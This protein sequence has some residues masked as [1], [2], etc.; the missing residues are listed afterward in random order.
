MQKTTDTTKNEDNIQLRPFVHLHT[1]TEFSLLDGATRI[2][3]MFKYAYSIGQPA[4]AITDH[5][6]MYG[7]LEFAKAAAK[8]TD[9]QM[10]FFEFMAKKVPFK[11]KP[12]I[13]C[14]VYMCP[15]RKAKQSEG[16][17]A[18]KLEHLVLLCK[19]ETGY[20]NLI[21]M[22]SIAN[23]EGFY[24][25]PRIDIDLL[26]QHVE[27]LVCLSGCLG[28]AV[29][30]ALLNG[31]YEKANN[32]A[33][34]FKVLFG[35]DY[36]IEIQ[37][38]N[39]LEQ[40][41]VLPNLIRIARENNIKL[42]ATND[43]HY[44]KKEDWAMQKVLQCIA[45]RKTLSPD[46]LVES[47]ATAQTAPLSHDATASVS[48]DSYF[49]THEYYIKNREEMEA[50]FS[51]CLD[52]IDNTIEI[53]NKCEPYFFE[54]KPLLPKFKPPKEFTPAK[55]LRKLTYDGLNKKYSEI[56][57]EIKLRADYE[58]GLIEKLGFVD[59]FLIVWDFI[60]FAENKGIAVGPGRGSGVGS[61]VAFALN[62]TKPDPL[63]YSL[64]FERFLNPDRISNPDFDIDFCV[65]RRDEVIEYVVGKYGI[66]NVCQ[67]I[68]FGSLK[69]KQA[70]KDV[71]RVLNKPYAEMDRYAKLF[72]SLSTLP[73]SMLIGLKKDKDNRDVSVSDLKELYEHDPSV[74]QIF[75]M[76]IKVEGFPRQTGIHPAGVIICRDPIYQ[77]IPLAIAS[78]KLAVASAVSDKKDAKKSDDFIVTTQFDMNECEQLGLLK[79]DF[80]GLRTLTD[81][82]NALDMI[83]KSTDKKIDF[84]SME[85]NNKAVFD[86]IGE[87]DTVGVFQL[88]SAGMTR[89]MVDLK[90]NCLED[91][92]AGVSLFRPGPMDYIPNYV[93]NKRNPKQIK[94]DHPML[95]S[96]LNVTYGVMVYQ[97][98][99][100][101]VAQQLAGYSVARADVLRAIIGKKKMELL[102]A[103]RKFFIYG[104]KNQG[105]IG[106]INN[107]VNGSVATKIFDDIVKFGNYAFN[108]SHATAYAYV[109]YQTAFLKKY[110]PVEYIASVLNNRI[111]KITDIAYYLRYAKQKGVTVLPPDINY[112]NAFFSVENGAI[113]IG[114]S[115]IKN[116][117]LSIIDHITK[118]REQN[119]YFS[120]F[121]DFITRMSFITINKRVLEGFILTGVFDGFGI[122]RAVLMLGYEMIM[123][124]A[125]KDREASESG[126][127]SM[128]DNPALT[129]KTKTEYPKA[130]EY[131]L[132]EKLKHEKEIAG[133]YL[134]GHPLENYA[135]F[136]SGF[137]Y[138]S[139]HFLNFNE[140]MS[141]D[142]ELNNTNSEDNDNISYL[143]N[144]QKI[145]LGGMLIEA[146]KRFT[147]LGREL[148]VGKLE[149][150]HGTIEVF[151]S[152]HI[153]NKY[154]EHFVKD[155]LVTL[156]GNV[157][158]RDDGAT[159]W[160]NEVSLLNPTGRE[161]NR[162]KI[163]FYCDK[164]DE[165]LVDELQEILLA[166]PGHDE[167]YIKSTHD[168]KVYALDIPTQICNAML[169]EIEGL[170]GNEGYKIA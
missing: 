149:D 129:I 122:A 5:G 120:D 158:L 75:D 71:G 48:G 27:G 55:Y 136:L 64:I 125:T 159:F 89:F 138:N 116:V 131:G 79:M 78:P 148:G 43:T 108:K 73:L 14:E 68:T 91:I 58:L 56:T 21:K 57:D 146:N 118:E 105:I 147:K 164:K 80:L 39:L 4:I 109:A 92:I 47:S 74:K 163:C 1:H 23:T 85:Y 117:G 96:I 72:P 102:D 114:L 6:N 49:L 115:A 28:G 35:D 3:D 104:D 42:V 100:I 132:W 36:Y 30:R 150:L 38:H 152:G 167:T 126:Q 17:K 97:E 11:V 101:Q 106:A 24:H 165:T 162:K 37:D 41:Q 123:A 8:F 31:E 62:I 26:K 66:E 169:M 166:Y 128:F 29:P 93:A 7:V 63:K 161:I 155:Q 67:I 130:E 53:A 145:T 10:D 141:N 143:Q 60:A 119:G 153:L 46:E 88:E 18:P 99:V 110:Y 13:G 98:Q 33:K 139:S 103:E 12:I 22:M 137:N 54:R 61:I 134:T 16:G 15:D 19:N 121:D 144:D 168:N 84:Y 156:S 87:G 81:I 69:S 124:R 90:P 111:G 76:A 50:L 25:K 95:E 45:M 65:D 112:S 9:P 157:R 77:H 82:K 127:F 70:F 135:D 140:G 59:Y 83:A 160:I 51:N 113:R 20:K 154:R 94:Y 133:I 107:G 40:R 34:E 2:S 142:A 151:L 170:L 44:L 32:I 86:M 52:A